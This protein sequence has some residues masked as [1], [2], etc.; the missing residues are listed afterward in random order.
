VAAAPNIEEKFL[1][2]AEL[3]L[4]GRGGLGQGPDSAGSLIGATLKISAD[5]GD[6]E[7][8]CGGGL[9]G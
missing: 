7:S 8:D 9:G 2:I 4:L 1:A 6:D 5:E 3:G